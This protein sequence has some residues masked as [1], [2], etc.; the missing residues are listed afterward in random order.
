MQARTSTEKLA[1]ASAKFDELQ[2]QA[3]Q[4]AAAAE[5]ARQG[6]LAQAA[7]DLERCRQD[8][9]KA[10]RDVQEQAQAEKL[11]LQERHRAEQAAC[12]AQ[13]QS[14]RHQLLQRQIQRAKVLLDFKHGAVAACQACRQ[15][16]GWHMQYT[17]SKP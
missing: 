1:A 5:T 15:A 6:L 11:S 9:D 17:C 8:R 3:L 10:V 12:Q 4:D 7:A 14:D 2:A 16:R 13:S